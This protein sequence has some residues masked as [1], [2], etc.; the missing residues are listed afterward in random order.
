MLAVG[1]TNGRVYI[2]DPNSLKRLNE[3]KEIIDPDKDTISIVKFSPNSE[4]LMVTYNP[5]ASL[6]VAYSTKTWKR[7]RTFAD[8]K[9]SVLA[10]DFSVDGK[11]FQVNTALNKIWYFDLNNE[12]Y[13]ENGNVM[14]KDE[15]WYSWT[16]MFG[17]PV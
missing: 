5:P 12:K 9:S 6:I 7:V 10:L 17:W 11:F 2:Y 15:K 14:L 3:I 4:M 1:C 16:C 13:M 8:C